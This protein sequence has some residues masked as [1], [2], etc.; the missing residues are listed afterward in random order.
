MICTRPV[1]LTASARLES[2]HLRTDVKPNHQRET[3][4]N[5]LG[6]ILP[7]NSCQI[8]SQVAT[9][10]EIQ[11]DNRCSSSRSWTFDY[12]I[13]Q[14]IFFPHGLLF[15][16]TCIHTYDDKPHNSIKDV[17]F[18]H[19]GRCIKFLCFLGAKK[20]HFCVHG[21]CVE[22]RSFHSSC[23]PLLGQSCIR[24]LTRLPCLLVI[25]LQIRA[26]PFIYFS[27]QFWT[28]FHFLRR[29]HLPKN[30]MIKLP[31]VPIWRNRQGRSQPW[32]S[33]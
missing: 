7:D 26:F 33:F 9:R 4:N 14:I 10:Y 21:E 25:A 32:T 23:K 16:F 30:G 27:F 13:Q 5:P 15:P 19:R 31:A 3:G 24:H 17:F 6:G 8:H 18:Y 20:K 12:I 28:K 1:W 2:C 29:L 11:I 22:I